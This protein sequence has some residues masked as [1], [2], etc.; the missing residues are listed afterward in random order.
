VK[1]K[2]PFTLLE[3]LIAVTLLS[4]ASSAIGWKLYRMI[5]IKRFTSQVSLFENR[6]MSC[7]QLAM[8]TQSDWEG[9]LQ[10]QEKQWT[11][12]VRCIDNPKAIG[13]S[14]LTLS[15]LQITLDGEEKKEIRFVFTSAGKVLPEGILSVRGGKDKTVNWK[16]PD[17]FS[18]FAKE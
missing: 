4:L 12:D 5:E 2:I 18:L 13:F 17:L 11:F 1:T 10:R 14:R 8:N 3:I 9:D 6:L 7:R 16:I 15:P